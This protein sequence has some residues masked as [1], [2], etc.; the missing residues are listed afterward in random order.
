MCPKC[1]Q[2]DA[3]QK[4]TAIVAGGTSSGSFSASTSSLVHQLAP[5]PAP[6]RPKGAPLGCLVPIL[7]LAGGT[8]VSSNVLEW[9]RLI[10]FGIV[11]AA[12][13]FHFRML[14]TTTK[15]HEEY[16]PLYRRAIQNWERLYYCHRDDVVFDPDR[17][18]YVSPR[19]LQDFIFAQS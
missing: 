9:V 17:Q 2:A 3:I 8:A 1:K 14:N 15:R 19:R 12:L 18:D 13:L 5:P 6:V 4:V 16:Q 7:V 11:A 10:A